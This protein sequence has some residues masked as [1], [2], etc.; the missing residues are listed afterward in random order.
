MK[1]SF[2]NLTD[3]LYIGVTLLIFLLMWIEYGADKLK[4]W[5]TSRNLLQSVFLGIVLSIVTSFVMIIDNLLFVETIVEARGA[6]LFVN[7]IVAVLFGP[8]IEELVYRG[9]IIDIL[10]RWFRAVI[11]VPASA[12]L[13]SL[14]H[15]PGNV[16]D[17]LLI[18]VIGLCFGIVYSIDGN[19]IPS[20]IAH[21]LS[22]IAVFIFIR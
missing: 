9:V 6:L 1:T 14:V 2:V 5:Y 3:L 20:T 10:G 18:F 22:N 17:F 7:I 16:V 11:S 19:L 15:V 4:K 13:F 8:F 12:V 21:S